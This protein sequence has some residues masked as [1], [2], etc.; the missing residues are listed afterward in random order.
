MCRLRINAEGRFLQIRQVQ[1]KRIR[2]RLER[3]FQG[4]GAWPAL[5]SE[6]RHKLVV[7]GMVRAGGIKQRAAGSELARFGCNRKCSMATGVLRRPHYARR[8]EEQIEM[9]RLR[10]E[11][12]TIFPLPR[13]LLLHCDFARSAEST[14]DSVRL[15]PCPAWQLS[16]GSDPEP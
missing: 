7:T 3:S 8:E 5:T 12:L 4:R 15:S 11:V 13:A 14:G 16:S 10:E 6:E 1:R 9:R 2:G